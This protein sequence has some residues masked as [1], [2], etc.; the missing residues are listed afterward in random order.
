MS[1]KLEKNLE[2]YTT[3]LQAKRPLIVSLSLSNT[4]L[5]KPKDNNNIQ[6]N[7]ITITTCNKTRATTF[8]NFSRPASTVTFNNQRRKEH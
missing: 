6:H 5:K 4:K 3:H 1:W 2:G 8:N 7:Q